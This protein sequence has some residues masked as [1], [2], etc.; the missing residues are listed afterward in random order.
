MYKKLLVM[1][2]MVISIIS[3]SNLNTFVVNDFDAALKIGEITGKDVIVMF[4][5]ESCYYC[6]KFKEETLIDSEIQKWLKT[7]FV[8]AEIFA[9]KNKKATY[10]GRTMNYLEL[11]GTFGVR[12]TPTFFFFNNKGEALSQLPGYVPKDVFLSILKFF[13]YFRKEK[14]SFQEFQ[15]KNI[16]LNIDK[17]V[18]NLSKK[19]IEFLLKNDPNTKL[20]DNK[21]DEYTNIVVEEKNKEL[22]NKYYIVIYEKK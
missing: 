21:L 8:F 1:F 2:L 12:G 14:I 6:K 9:D 16:D 10:M 3:F 22:E 13:K 20:Y 15:E 17:K 5:S 19:D 11:F 4:S 7:E 18:L